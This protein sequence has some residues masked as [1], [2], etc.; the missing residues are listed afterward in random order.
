MSGARIPSWP[1]GEPFDKAPTFDDLQRQS[2]QKVARLRALLRNVPRWK[3]PDNTVRYDAAAAAEALEASSAEM[4]DDP[5]LEDA[6]PIDPVQASVVLQQR[7]LQ[8]LTTVV[9][10]RGDVVRLCTETIRTM[11]EPLKMGLEMM[12]QTQQVLRSRLAKYDDMWDRMVLL[13]EELQSTQAEREATTERRKSRAHMQREAFD[14]AKQYL[15]DALDKFQLTVEAGDAVDLL[16][17]I[18]PDHLEAFI[19]LGV[20]PAHMEARARRLL[21]ILRARRAK[22]ERH[23]QSSKA[24]GKDSEASEAAAP[25]P[26]VSGQAVN[27]S[28]GPSSSST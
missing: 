17:S 1:Q 7:T 13:V 5:E 27:G 2:G 3:C 6:L 19:D 24:A 9:R 10:E 28:A 21:A 15:P 8:L 11:G 18:E 16:R 12:R 22:G 26:E 20:L 4:D 14:L 25:D 23:G